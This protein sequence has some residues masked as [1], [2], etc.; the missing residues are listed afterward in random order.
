MPCR[1]LTDGGR[2]SVYQGGRSF[3]NSGSI[4]KVGARNW[5]S[6]LFIGN[7]LALSK[8]P[9]NNTKKLVP[10][11]RLSSFTHHHASD[12]TLY[13]HVRKLLFQ[14]FTALHSKRITSSLLRRII[15]FKWSLC[16]STGF[17]LIVSFICIKCGAL[18]R[19]KVNISG[20]KFTMKFDIENGRNKSTGT[21]IKESIYYVL[22]EEHALLQSKYPQLKKNIIEQKMVYSL[23]DW[24]SWKHLIES[25]NRHHTYFR[26]AILVLSIQKSVWKLLNLCRE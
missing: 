1:E 17:A 9:L 16:K 11:S 14:M 6:Q 15:I 3:T 2:K 21:G 25:L 20:I 12:T 23:Q 22:V 8:C 19:L 10:F 26:L 13:M 5:A 24:I 7:A 4:R 18:Q